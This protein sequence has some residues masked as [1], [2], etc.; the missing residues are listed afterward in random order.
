MTTFEEFSAHVSRVADRYPKSWLMRL[1]CRFE[2]RRRI[3][4]NRPLPFEWVVEGEGIPVGEPI[5]VFHR[6]L[7]DEMPH[8]AQGAM[9][10]ALLQRGLRAN[11]FQI[12]GR[13]TEDG[14]WGITL[15]QPRWVDKCLDA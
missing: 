8:C 6:I 15:I 5:E 12:L 14:R 7:Y 4:Q 10:N 1:K 9:T 13:T 3:R 2:W 11:A